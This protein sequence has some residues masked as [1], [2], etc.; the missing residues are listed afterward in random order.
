M[1]IFSYILYYLIILPISLLPFWVLYILSDGLYYL[2]YHV[3]GYRKK[4]VLTNLKNSFP[5]REEKERILI[6]KKFY[7][8]LCDLTVESIKTFT[9]SQKQ[10]SKRVTCTNP[11][12]MDKF[13]EQGKSVIM[14]GGHYNNWELF[15]VAVDA[16]I[17]HQTVG[18]YKPL[19]NKFF[20]D[21]MQKTRSKYGLIMISTKKIKEFFEDNVNRLTTIIFGIDQSPS[22]PNNCYWMKFLNQDT[23]VLF[24]AENYAKKYNYPVVFAN[25]EKLKRGHYNLRFLEVSSNPS[26]THHGEI[27]EQLIH[28]IEKDIIAKPEFWLWSHKRWK[29]K[30]PNQT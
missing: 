3:I 19:N 4:V 30:K 15:A 16:L 7:R 12:V 18:I 27:T 17:R 14:A 29:H 25:L 20:D 11:E 24:G 1:I 2:L 10:I 5:D 6:A 8:H 13:F 26:L 22:N 21:E 28:L 9:I 23:G